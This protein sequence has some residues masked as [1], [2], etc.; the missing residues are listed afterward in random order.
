MH[1]KHHIRNKLHNILLFYYFNLKFRIKNEDMFTY[2][3]KKGIEK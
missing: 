2:T 1:I 3:E